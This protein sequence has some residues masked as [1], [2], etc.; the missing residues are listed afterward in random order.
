MERDIMAIQVS[1]FMI[2]KGGNQWYIL[3]DK[4]LKGGL[5]VVPTITDRDAIDVDSLKA[6]MLVI[7]QADMKIYQMETSMTSWREFNLG[8]G[9]PVRQTVQ[10][11]TN[12][13]KANDA[14]NFPLNLGRSAVIFKLAV[15]TPCKVEVFSTVQ[16]DE[17]NPYQFLATSDH[18]EDDGSTLLTD[19]T[20][21]KG[22]RFNIFA[23]LEE[24]N[25]TDVYFRITNTDSVEKNVNLT[26]QFLPLESLSL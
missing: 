25:A 19:G 8:G 16:R 14:Q 21:M 20:V 10:F 24:G 22:R 23:N 9:S 5:R 26:V 2:P 17:P 7:V 18:L 3:E 6:G 13:L 11:A 1:S 12:S 15:D 4:Y